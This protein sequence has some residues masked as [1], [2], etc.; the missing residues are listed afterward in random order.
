MKNRF[1]QLF[2]DIGE[3]ITS[4]AIVIILMVPF[5][6]YRFYEFETLFMKWLPIPDLQSRQLASRLVSLVFITITLLFM[7]NV[8]RLFAGIKYILA[9]TAF[10]LNIFFWAMGDELNIYFVI[11]ISAVIAS[12]DYGQAHLFDVMWK[13]RNQ[14]KD[15]EDLEEELESKRILID[16]ANRELNRLN[17]F[18][19][20]YNEI[21]AK[22]YCDECDRTFPSPQARNG[23]KCKPLSGSN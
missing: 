9:A 23:H 10:T 3:F 17:P 8:K 6:W 14:E 19:A 1:Y 13:E 12:M 18:V 2:D 16:T 5:M 21:K 22:C 20:E 4:R 11:F 15:L 7:V